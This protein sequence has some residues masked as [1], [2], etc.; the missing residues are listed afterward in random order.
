MAVSRMRKVQI[1]AHNAAKEAIVAA[2]RES[3]VI[4]ITEPAREGADSRDDSA[5]RDTLRDLQ[6]RLGKIEH[7]KDVLKPYVPKEK[8]SL[9]AMLN[10]RIVLDAE[11][12]QSMVAQF[13]TDDWYARVVEVEG[14]MRSAEAEIARKEA[15]ADEMRHWKALDAPIEELT[16]TERTALALITV[17]SSAVKSLNDE[18]AEVAR[19]S[20]SF[21]VSESGSSAYLAVIYLRDEEPAVSPVLKRHGARSANVAGATGR[22]DE[23]TVRLLGDADSLRGRIEELK[24][25]AAELA[26]ERRTVLVILDEVRE[27]L[28]KTAVQEKFA[29]TRDTFMIEGWM[30]ASDEEAVRERLH[31]V[32]PEFEMVGR[33]PE[34]GEDVPIC[35][36]NGSAVHP[37]EFV[38]T[39][40][41]RPSYQERDPTPLLAPFFILFFG[42]CVSDAGYGVTLAAVSFFFM[43][44]MQPGGGRQLMKLLMMG[45]ISTA[46][47]GA[48]TGGWFGLHAHML[49]AWLRAIIV[50]NPL[51]EPMKMLNV[52][53]ILGIVQV[54]TGLVIKMASDIRRGQWADAVFDQLVWVFFLI[55]LVPLGYSF[56]LGGSLPPGAMAVSKNGAMVAGA[57]V[58]LTGARKNSNPIMKVLGGVLKLYDVVGYFGDVLSYARLLALG[59]ATGAIAMAINGVAD[60]AVGIPIVGPVAAVVILVGGH[61]FNM[62]VN[63]L[64]GFVHS[65]R[66][67]YLEFFSKFFTGGGRAFAPFRVEKRYSTVRK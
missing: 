50:M 11:Q 39:L 45:G 1:L 6:T 42:L 3:G 15:L 7:I 54:I 61:L 24:G 47:V 58:V 23:E 5:R 14:A 37:F 10:P 33:D 4:H 62:A 18:L 35:L 27:S 31:E 36:S 44:K 32:T 57:V 59:L 34:K 30:R 20:E 19:E 64:G 40:Y 21:V 38:T 60:M 65:A 9:D 12:L 43:T 2:L 66:L 17:E 41:G 52:V 16:G 53:F 22:P 49:P 51:Q 46:V 28:A 63:C 13:D 55:F 25:Q 29:G 56:I 48:V 26:R 8:R 67:Q